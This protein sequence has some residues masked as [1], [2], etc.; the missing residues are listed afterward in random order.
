MLIFLSFTTPLPRAKRLTEMAVRPPVATICR[1][2]AMLCRAFQLKAKNL[3]D[4][5]ELCLDSR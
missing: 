1:N 5:C 3:L 2:Y 4:S